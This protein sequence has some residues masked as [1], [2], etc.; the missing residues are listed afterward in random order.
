M[1]IGLKR[2]YDDPEPGDGTRILRSQFRDEA[3]NWHEFM[4][5]L[6]RRV[7]CF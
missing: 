2:V 1:A 4:R 5:G 6:F 7:G 3:G